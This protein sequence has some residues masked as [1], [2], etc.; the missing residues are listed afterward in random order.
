MA[1]RILKR[2]DEHVVAAL[3]S[4]IDRALCA[5]VWRIPR[6]E[7]EILRHIADGKDIAANARAIGV[8][9]NTVKGMLWRS[10]RRLGAGSA[11]LTMYEA[12]V[13]QRRVS[14]GPH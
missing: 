14:R 11:L 2:Q 12:S 7:L 6:R 4:H 9:Y 10:Y 13:V 1:G 5:R 3:A 8:K